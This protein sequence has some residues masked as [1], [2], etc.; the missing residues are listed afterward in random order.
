MVT[1]HDSVTNNKKNLRNALLSGFYLNSENWTL[2]TLGIIVGN[3]SIIVKERH[4]PKMSDC[5]NSCSIL[6]VICTHI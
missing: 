5:P 4:R 3:D 2:L 6:T 1:P